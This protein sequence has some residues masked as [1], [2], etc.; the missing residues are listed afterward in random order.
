MAPP[1]LSA[2]ASAYG[3]LMGLSPVLQIRR[4]FREKSSRDVSIGYFLV[5]LAGFS[6]WVAYG[7]AAGN[8]VLVVPNAVAL[9]V[10]IVLVIVALR[11]RRPAS[12]A[13]AAGHLPGRPPPAR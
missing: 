5:L 1:E 6:L 3:V 9:L 2:A 4:M 8:M 12:G 7:S 13:D 10:G 11:L